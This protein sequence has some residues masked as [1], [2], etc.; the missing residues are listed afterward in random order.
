M[1]KVREE[2]QLTQTAGYKEKH[3][4]VGVGASAG[5]LEAIN[6]L[7]DHLPRKTSFSFI[8]IQHLSPDYKSLMSELLTKHTHMAVNDAEDGM[9]VRPDHVYVIPSKKNM[10][11]KN[12]KLRLIDKNPI[13]VPNTAI[14]IFFESLAEEKKEQGICVILSGTGSDGTKGAA[15]VKE[16]GGLVI[17]QDPNSAKFDGMPNSAIS[18]GLADLVL[19]PSAISGAIIRYA[20]N[21]KGITNLVNLANQEEDEVVNE[22]IEVIRKSTLHDFSY[23]KRQTIARRIAKRMAY[24]AILDLKEYLLYLQNNSEEVNVLRKEFLIGVTRFFR[25]PAAFEILKRKVIPELIDK[26]KDKQPIKVWV[27]ACSTGEEAYTMAILFREAILEKG[28]D[29]EVKIFATDVDADAVD[30]AAKGK[31]SKLIESDVSRERLEK[32]FIE[33][34]TGYTVNQ[35]IRK[36]V[37]FAQH[38]II[39]DPPFSKIDLVSCRN[40]L[41]YMKPV[42]QRKV[43]S[44]FHFSLNLGGYLFL[45]SSENANDFSAVLV[46]VNKKWNIFKTTKESENF[47]FD[48]PLGIDNSNGRMPNPSGLKTSRNLLHHKLNEVFCETVMEEFVMAAVYIDETYNLIQASGNYKRFVELPEQKFQLNILKLVAPEISVAL[49]VALRKS[50]KANEKVTIPKIRVKE[51]GEVK[52][53]DIIVKPFISHDDLTKKMALIVF[54]QHEQKEKISLEESEILDHQFHQEQF[55]ELELEL[56]ETKESLHALMEEMETA[57]EEL[58]S[59]NE[60]LLS[61]NEELQSTNEE[62]QSLNEE[63]HT[64]NAEHQQKIKE[65]IELNDDLNNYFRSTEIGQIFID[66][67]L[68]IRKYTPT[69]SNQINIIESDIGRPINHFSFNIK[70]EDLVKDI[71]AVIKTSCFLEK[72]VEL[73]NGH[74]YLMRILPYERQDKETDGVVV[75][76]VDITPIKNL[77]N[78]LSGILNGS[79][80]GISAFKSI[81]DMHGGI[82]DFEWILTNDSFK[83]MFGK[84]NEKLEGKKLLMT[85][86]NMK[87]TGLF[88]KFVQIMEEGKILLTEVEYEGNWLEVM[89]VKIHQG[90]AVTFADINEKKTSE[91]KMVQAYDDLKEAEEN[92]KKLNNHLERRVEERTEALSRSEERFRLVSQATNDAVWDWNL[93]TNEIWWSDSFKNMFGYENSDI[94]KG[95]ESWYNRIHSEDKQEV[96]DGI[97][98]VINSGESQWGDEYRF[99]KADGSYAYVYNRGYIV[100]NENGTPYRMLGSK[101]DLTNL[102]KVEDELRHS[103]ETLRKINHDLDTFIYTASHDLKSPIANLEGLIG[104][105]KR[106]MNGRLK[107]KEEKLLEMID[108]SILKFNTTIKGLTEV[109]KVQKDVDTSKSQIT[110][111]NILQTVKEDIDYMIRDSNAKIT[112]DF[113]VEGMEYNKAHLK[114]IFYNLISNAIKYR[115]EQKPLEIKVSTE[116][117]EDHV[118]LQVKDNGLGMNKDQQHKLFSIFK[119]FHT[120]VE[121]TGI[122]LYIVKRIIENN[123]GKITVESEEG[124]GT[125]FCV[126]FDLIHTKKTKAMAKQD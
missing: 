123:N 46:D 103:N 43:L 90:I 69:I 4:I 52:M 113:Q 62:L 24:L 32:F 78:L 96:I 50:N 121:G 84:K 22:I 51:N 115:D 34:G 53:V 7:F 117:R 45:G 92:L 10:T 89:G 58:Q 20:E 118:V 39:K 42:L 18:H 44:T 97:Q 48:A 37:V 19:S 36:M 75:T 79:I 49:S 63:L 38:N 119:R 74:S 104:L 109:T 31:F 85:F 102:K 61:S 81:E 95:I 28:R 122:G 41:I 70:D 94:E 12:G 82:L 101:V 124:K 57:N 100:H 76:F 55:K 67:N 65:L 33:N 1:T 99:L 73:I 2:K 29:L 66:K 21:G 26:K 54:K 105:L 60:E 110:F 59:S 35:H 14:D 47:I 27:T 6:E 111:D 126:F 16:V 77:N 13:S 71:Q 120:H 9:T 56:N 72:E 108:L 17:V 15:A 8:I 40:L 86:P 64:V 23:Y 80:N 112:S 11:I 88:Q 3:F 93:I 30:F 116:L 107:E 83:E 5:G 91:R 125:T 87:E 114:S 25:D 98:Q 68:L 106:Q